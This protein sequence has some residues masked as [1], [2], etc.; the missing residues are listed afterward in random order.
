MNFAN[1]QA[2]HK[3]KS[4]LQE[5]KNSHDRHWDGRSPP[6]YCYL[7]V[8]SLKMGVPFWHPYISS[9]SHWPCPIYLYQ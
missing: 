2:A 8:L 6:L 3:Q 7:A 5:S 9:F 4:L 1:T